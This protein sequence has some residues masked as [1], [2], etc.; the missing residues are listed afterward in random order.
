MTKKEKQE[1]IKKVFADFVE[2]KGAWKDNP[3]I[4]VRKTQR[5]FIF[6]P[7][8]PMMAEAM[9]SKYEGKKVVK[10]NQEAA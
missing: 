3:G 10:S 8:P 1:H 5:G 7:M 2:G 4:L 6:A 9:K